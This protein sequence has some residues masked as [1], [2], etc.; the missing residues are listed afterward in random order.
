MLQASE[1]EHGTIKYSTWELHDAR[2]DHKIRMSQGSQPCIEGYA[3]TR[4]GR[5]VTVEV[6]IHDGMCHLRPNGVGSG[7]LRRDLWARF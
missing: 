7:H 1:R 3:T 4:V 6:T 2:D 5:E